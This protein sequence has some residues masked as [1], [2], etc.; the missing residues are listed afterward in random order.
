MTDAETRLWSVV[1]MKQLKG[2]QFYRQ[3]IIGSYIVDFFCPKAKLVIEVDGSQHYESE[4]LEA[5]RKRDKYMK[6]RGFKVLRYNDIE[7]LKNI[8]GVAESI[9]ENMKD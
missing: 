1:R 3:R 9:I 6:T 7:V 8:E 4:A 2:F 5:D